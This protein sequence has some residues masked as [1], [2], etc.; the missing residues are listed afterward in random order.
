MCDGV[1]S[2]DPLVAVGMLA[3]G[4]LAQGLGRQKPVKPHLSLPSFSWPFIK[5]W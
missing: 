3:H 1:G 2:G 5:G 4:M